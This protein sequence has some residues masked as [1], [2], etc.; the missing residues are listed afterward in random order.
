MQTFARVMLL[1]ALV[2][3]YFARAWSC[4]HVLGKFSPQ[5]QVSYA[6]F[7]RHGLLAMTEWGVDIAFA[8]P[9]FWLAI[10]TVM[11]PHGERR[12]DRLPSKYSLLSLVAVAALLAMPMQ[13]QL[14]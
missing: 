4:T 1:L 5:D 3:A 13:V 14:A 9:I 2:P 6:R 12:G 10:A 11:E 7:D 8:A